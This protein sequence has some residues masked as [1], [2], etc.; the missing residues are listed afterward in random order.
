MGVR[1]LPTERETSPV[2]KAYIHKKIL[3]LT[4]LWSAIPAIVVVVVVPSGRG[5]AYS[6]HIC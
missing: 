2:V 4:M 6:G 5:P 1:K 3:A